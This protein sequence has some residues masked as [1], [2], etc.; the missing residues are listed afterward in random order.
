MMTGWRADPPS[1]D[2]G[3]ISIKRWEIETECQGMGEL[4]DPH[5]DPCAKPEGK[6]IFFIFLC[7]CVGVRER[8]N[9]NVMCEHVGMR[10]SLHTHHCL[11]MEV[12]R[13]LAGV[14]SLLPPCESQEPNSDLQAWWQVP[15]PTEPPC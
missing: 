2:Q 14:D 11:P 9:E 12:R 7:V 10:V 1:A 4:R 5:P 6:N 8:Q 15:L 3:L 13:K